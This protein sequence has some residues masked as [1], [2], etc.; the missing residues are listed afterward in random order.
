MGAA[1]HQGNRSVGDGSTGGI[2]GQDGECLVLAGGNRRHGVGVEDVGHRVR[3]RIERHGPGA[4][5]LG[6]GFMM[7]GWE[8]R[9]GGELQRTE[10]SV[11][12]WGRCY[13]S[14][15]VKSIFCLGLRGR[16][17]IL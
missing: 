3:W 6:L 4:A 15:V 12:G 8:G 13:F 14:W 9:R 5:D 1:N 2:G 17:E 7:A 11:R 10:E 16:R